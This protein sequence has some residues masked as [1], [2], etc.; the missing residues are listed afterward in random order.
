[1]YVAMNRFRIRLGSE[2]AFEKIWAERE[3]HLDTV[4]GFQSF[5]LLRGPATED[6]CLYASH[7]LWDSEEDFVNWTKSEAF[8]K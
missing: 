3:T 7:T 1:M 4:P 5:H 6:H 8:R 2:A